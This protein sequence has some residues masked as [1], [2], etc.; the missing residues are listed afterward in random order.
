MQYMQQ[1]MML[2]Q[3]GIDPGTL[4]QPAKEAPP[5]APEPPQG[6]T[7]EQRAEMGEQEAAVFDAVFAAQQAQHMQQMQFV[8]SVRKEQQANNLIGSPTGP[9]L[10]CRFTDNFRPLQ[11]CKRFFSGE[12]CRRAEKCTYAHCP[13]ELHP[14]SP[15][16]P[17]QDLLIPEDDTEEIDPVKCIPDMR[18]KKKREICNKWKKD[19]GCVLG[20]ACP[21]AHGEHEIGTVALVVC[22][23]VKM[24]L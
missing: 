22:E 2:Q 9:L 1:C 15:E 21:F 17:N 14:N 24:K 16:F 4:G 23:K 12:G 3:Q 5:P 20:Q 19:G 11:Y 6:L 13:E 8:H 7:A 18:M 10:E